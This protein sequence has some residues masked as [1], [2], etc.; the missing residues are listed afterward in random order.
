MK[1]AI[2]LE[3]NLDLA[4]YTTRDLMRI[5]NRSARTIRDWNASNKIPHSI[6]PGIWLKQRIDE[7]LLTGGGP[8]GYRQTF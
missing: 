1:R 6:L 2:E 8:G 7:F 4:T 5:F 3:K